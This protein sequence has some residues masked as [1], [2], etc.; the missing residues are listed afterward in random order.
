MAANSGDPYWD[1]EEVPDFRLVDLNDDGYLDVVAQVYSQIQ[2]MLG[3]AGGEFGAATVYGQE[4]HHAYTLELDI[5]NFNGDEY[6]DVVTMW[7]GNGT[8]IIPYLGD[9]EGG[10]IPQTDFPDTPATS[11][12]GLQAI[13]LTGDGLDDIATVDTTDNAFIVYYG[14]GDGT[15]SSAG[16]EL[17]SNPDGEKAFGLASGDAN[18]D[19]VPDLVV[20][21][22]MNFYAAFNNLVGFPFQNAGV[23]NGLGGESPFQVLDV[24]A[25]GETDLISAGNRQVAVY[26]GSAT[27]SWLAA[28]PVTTTLPSSPTDFAVG[29][30]TGDGLPD[31]VICDRTTVTVLRGKGTGGFEVFSSSGPYLAGGQP[32]FV[33]LADI[34]KD[35]KLDVAITTFTEPASANSDAWGLSLLYNRL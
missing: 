4:G 22:A 6:P 20:R 32:T 31:L 35:G 14:A 7:Y 16:T 26:M 27:Q 30:L 34:N 13:D 19:G 28:A 9:G 11:Y 15:F 1:D 33:E 3:Q 8:D 23:A 29:D 10:L 17:P 18:S 2:V 21:T 5:A 24:N 12:T 25:D